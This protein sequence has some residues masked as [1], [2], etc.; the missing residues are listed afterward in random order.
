MKKKHNSKRSFLKLISISYFLFLIKIP[1]TTNK[2]KSKIHWI[3]KKDD[4]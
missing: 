3:L 4:F 2:I 1:I